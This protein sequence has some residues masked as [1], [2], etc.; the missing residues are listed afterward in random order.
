MN[1][2]VECERETGVI[3]DG[4]GRENEELA[5]VKNEICQVLS[6]QIGLQV[7]KIGIDLRSYIALGSM[8]TQQKME[9][10]GN[11]PLISYRTDS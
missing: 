3:A 7:R 8:L 10:M 6:K 5:R 2:E 9:R 4:K 11:N 1:S